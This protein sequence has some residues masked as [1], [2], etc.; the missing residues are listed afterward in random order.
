MVPPGRQPRIGRKSAQSERSIPEWA[1]RSARLCPI[2]AVDSHGCQSRSYRSPVQPLHPVSKRRGC[3]ARPSASVHVVHPRRDRAATGFGPIDDHSQS[4]SGCQA[5]DAC[6]DSESK[7]D[8]V[9]V[10]TETSCRPAAQAEVL[11]TVWESVRRWVVARKAP[12]LPASQP[13]HDVPNHWTLIMSAA[14]DDLR[15]RLRIGSMAYSSEQEASEGDMDHGLG[16]IQAAI[17]GADDPEP[18][19][20]DRVLNRRAG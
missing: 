16:D 8:G 10:E 4:R 12:L 6:R 7:E 9:R 1:R 18:Q 15:V 19:R 20:R 3:P 5:N 14:G 11:V 17:R 2:G 13:T